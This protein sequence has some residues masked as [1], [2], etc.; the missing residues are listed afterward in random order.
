[1]FLAPLRTLNWRR[2]I[3]SLMRQGAVR[4]LAKTLI[5]NPQKSTPAFA[6]ESRY[7]HSIPCCSRVKC[8]V[9]RL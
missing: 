7:A 9:R 2:R 1:V 3:L 4:T 5:Q 8:T 6:K